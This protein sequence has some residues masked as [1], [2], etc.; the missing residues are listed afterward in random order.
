MS[1]SLGPSPAASKHP[2]HQIQVADNPGH[3]TVVVNG[4]RVADSRSTLALDETGYE[5]VIYFP[6]SDVRT[7]LFEESDSRTT[8]PFK[9]EAHYYAAEV[10]GKSC[11]VAWVYP[12]VY[13]EVAAIAG[14]VAFYANR[15]TL[16]RAD[17][18]A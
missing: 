18:G 13:D 6:V 1:K 4:E 14:Y 8:C 16:A 7:E 5:R 12:V 9:G 11:D 3:W 15:I 10:G 17:D 2:G